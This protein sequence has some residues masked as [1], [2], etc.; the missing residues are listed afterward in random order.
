M[1]VNVGTSTALPPYTVERVG[2]NTTGALSIIVNEG[3]IGQ[4]LFFIYS[5]PATG[6]VEIQGPG[7]VGFVLSDGGSLITLDGQGESVHLLCIDDGTGNGDW[8]V[9]GGD[10]YI[11]S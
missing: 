4:E 5:V 3:K 1:V 9:V 2:N 11:I 8:Y 10:E 6:I 7:G